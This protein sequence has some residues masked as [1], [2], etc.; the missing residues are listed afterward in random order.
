M[1]VAESYLQ[2]LLK[3]KSQVLKL[4]PSW[5]GQVC[6]CAQF[7]ELNLRNNLENAREHPQVD[8]VRRCVE[9]HVLQESGLVLQGQV[10]RVILKNVQEEL[11]VD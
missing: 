4:R 5:R 8:R 2:L 11:P 3:V 7:V 9:L 1:G 6:F 10:D